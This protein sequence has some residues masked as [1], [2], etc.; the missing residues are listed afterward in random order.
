MTYKLRNGRGSKQEDLAN[1]SHVRKSNSKIAEET[2]DANIPIP[3]FPIW[4]S[5]ILICCCATISFV[6]ALTG[7]FVFDDSEA[8]INNEDVRTSTP[9]SSIFY[10]DYWGTR[11][12]HPN[13]HK[14][15]RPINVLSFRLNYWLSGGV[16]IAR[17]FKLTNLLLHI[18]ISVLS[19]SIFDRMFGGN[20]P[21][22]SL[23][24]SLLFSVHPIHC[25]AVAGIVGRADLLCALFF[26]LAFLSYCKS[27]DSSIFSIQI[28]PAV[29]WL[30]LTMIFSLVSMLCKEQGITV[31]GLCSAYDV[32]NLWQERDRKKRKNVIMRHIALALWGSVL[33]FGRWF[34]MGGQVPT[35]QPVDNPA[36]FAESFFT[37]VVSYNYIYALNFWLLLC[38]DWLCFDWAM[39]CV[40]LVT[41]PLDLRVLAPILLWVMMT[42][43][44]L[45]WF[46]T[47]TTNSAKTLALGL[48]LLIVSFL[49][50]S[51]LLFRVGFVIA[52]RVLYLP[53][54]GFCV[55]ITL[56]VRQLSSLSPLY[57]HT[58]R[59]SFMMLLVTLALKSCQ[60]SREW[61]TEQELFRSALS[62]C[63]LNA[64]VHYNVAKNAA[65]LGDK[66][67]A[68]EEYAAALKLYPEY[69]QAMNNLGNLLRDGGHLS[70][71]EKLLSQAVNIRP[72]FAAAWMNLGIV[73]AGLKKFQDAEESYK[74]ALQNRPKYPDCYYNLGNLFLEQ[75]RH[76]DAYEAW[77]NATDLKPTHVVA[78]SNMVIM[79]DSIGR[80]ELAEEVGREALTYLPN[81]AGL[82][83]NLANTLGKLKQFVKAERHFL[84][85]TMLDPENAKYHANLG[86]LYHRWKKYSLAEKRYL[87][88]LEL[89]PTLQTAK[90]N[91]SM[92]HKNMSKRRKTSEKQ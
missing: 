61:G 69:E 63:P 44:G 3:I 83:F 84:K 65:D 58:I 85:A 19:L 30:D 18:V 28:L 5:I 81:E 11:L 73:Q 55:L 53:S 92:L 4:T 40:P 47:M 82:H 79:L 21:K 80:R 88:A 48:A 36:S 39:G 45:R 25:E 52:E 59:S 75:G 27:V 67:L 54:A 57:H 71:A 41:S 13:S 64:K 26:F 46:F 76:D 10:N 37:R 68:L 22:A 89:D 51:N 60:R 16:L 70:E 35:F 34:V 9:V 32:I 77:R 15:Y 29:I 56:G 24:A 31:I 50:A 7:D 62:V 2:W 78:W 23:L 49:P 17:S 72:N 42:L 66:Q 6:P 43:L 74:T 86:V 20:C 12:N 38:P 33:L 90:D 1:G 8:I 91:L 14:S 87:K